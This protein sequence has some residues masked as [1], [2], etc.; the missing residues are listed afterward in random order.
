MRHMAA[1]I[2]L[3]TALLPLAAMR[4]AAVPTLFLAGDSTLAIKLDSKRP[5]TG[6][7]EALA[8][9]VDAAA[10]RIDNRARN[11]RSTR[12]FIDEGLWQSL[13]RDAKPGDFVA[14]QFG[15]N[16]E[17]PSKTD[18]YT[19]PVAYRANL[20]RFV[21]DTRARRATPLLLTPVERRTFDARGA[22]V[23][24]HAEYAAIVR[25]VA[26]SMTVTLV[27]MGRASHALLSR[28]GPDSSVAL[29][30][31]VPRSAHP[32]YPDGVADDT[33]FSPRGAAVM[34]DLFVRAVRT[35]KL[36]LARAM[37]RCAR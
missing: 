15:H 4:R 13:V 14:I 26:A 34:S 9:C 24:T 25:E 36:A 3:V 7:G 10:L 32:N 12:T 30:L 31:H 17:V 35:Q 1:M 22:A 19:T 6:W 2:W 5:E 21:E 37:D 28:M 29:Y 8:G 27:D 23:E 16:D 33:H 18:R 11:G 20:V